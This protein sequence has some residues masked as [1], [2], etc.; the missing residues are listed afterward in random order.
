[1]PPPGLPILNR[2]LRVYRFS[3]LSSFHSFLSSGP[4]PADNVPTDAPS[5]LT[6]SP[7]TPPPNSIADAGPAKRQRNHVTLRKPLDRLCFRQ[8]PLLSFLALHFFL[9]IVSLS[10]HVYFFVHTALH[11]ICSTVGIAPSAYVLLGAYL[12]PG[13]VLIQI[14]IHR[15]RDII[16]CIRPGAISLIFSETQRRGT[17]HLHSP[18]L[19]SH[20]LPNMVNADEHPL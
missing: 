12:A 9:F 11:P 10:S 17:P 5:P 7:E 13:D 2:L 16:L 19:W 6:P 20:T 14:F 4:L 15:F 3:S 18:V 1:M 8:T